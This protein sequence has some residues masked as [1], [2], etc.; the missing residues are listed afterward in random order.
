MKQVI[1]SFYIPFI[2]ISKVR[3][4]LAKK[5]LDL[6]MLKLLCLLYY[7]ILYYI[8]MVNNNYGTG[9]SINIIYKATLLWAKKFLSSINVFI[10]GITLL[11]SLSSS[12][13]SSFSL[14][15]RIESKMEQKLIEQIYIYITSKT[16]T[17]AHGL[18]YN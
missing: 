7:I 5:I 17:Q 13:P 12:L 18:W 2:V 9:V 8:D 1:M 3:K 11:C 10:K 15:F 4:Q 16:H 6:N 14:S